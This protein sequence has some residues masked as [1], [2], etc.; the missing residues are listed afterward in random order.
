MSDKE[1]DTTENPNEPDKLSTLQVAASTIAAAFGVQSRK[2]RER[3]FA[4]GRLSQFVI[5][6]IVF[7]ATFALILIGIVVLV[8]R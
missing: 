1:P 6:G 4:R 8:T 2:N 5:A 7:T 3:D